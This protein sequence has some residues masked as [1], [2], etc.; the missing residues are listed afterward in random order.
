MRLVQ[1][2]AILCI[3]VSL[4]I[5][6]AI[7]L[8]PGRAISDFT[9]LSEPTALDVVDHFEREAKRDR[10][11]EARQAIASFTKPNKE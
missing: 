1:L 11:A 2:A 10:F 4:V 7:K 6:L 5:N 8:Q 9:V 3:P